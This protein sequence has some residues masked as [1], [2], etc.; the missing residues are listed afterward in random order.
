MLSIFLFHL[1]L[2]KQKE[3]KN[4]KEK[5]NIFYEKCF[6]QWKLFNEHS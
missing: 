4:E 1:L 3:K 6:T 5:E 2:F